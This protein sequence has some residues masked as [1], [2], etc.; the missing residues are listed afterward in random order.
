MLTQQ[1]CKQLVSASQYIT[2]TS[3]K[4]HQHL[5]GLCTLGY[6]QLCICSGKQAL[7]SFQGEH[8]SSQTSREETSS[9][10][11]SP[12]GTRG[13]F[14]GA[15]IKVCTG[16]SCPLDSFRKQREGKAL[17]RNHVVRVRN[18]T[19]LGV[20]ESLLLWFLTSE[21]QASTLL[22]A[23]HRGYRDTWHTSCSLSAFS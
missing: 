9:S 5:S 20:E 19:G 7:G 11:H 12:P 2:T 15:E 3:G 23:Q 1:R 4:D 16:S 10:R 14:S 22:A 21:I 17:S 13:T 8:S 6:L 18:H